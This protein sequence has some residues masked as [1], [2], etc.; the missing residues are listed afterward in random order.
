MTIAFQDGLPRPCL[1]CGAEAGV[2]WFE[3]AG[4]MEPLDMARLIAEGKAGVVTF[5]AGGRE[6]AFEGYETL[7]YL[8]RDAESGALLVGLRRK[9]GAA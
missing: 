2:L 7:A 3:L 9:E 8:R 1:W 4:G 5:M 6:T